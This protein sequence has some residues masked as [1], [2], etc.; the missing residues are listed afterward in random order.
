MW[1]QN[2]KKAFKLKCEVILPRWARRRGKGSWTIGESGVPAAAKSFKKVILY[3]IE[4][5][6]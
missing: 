5:Q 2:I 3:R 1:T 4:N 6:F